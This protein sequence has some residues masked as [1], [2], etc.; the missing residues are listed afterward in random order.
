MTKIQLTFG[1]IQLTF[2]KI[3][4]TFGKIQLTFGKIQ[5]TFGKKILPQ[6]RFLKKVLLEKCFAIKID[7]F[8]NFLLKS[9]AS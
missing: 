9:Y 6:N 4:L 3:Q 8:V 5:L 1:K 2:G 7:I